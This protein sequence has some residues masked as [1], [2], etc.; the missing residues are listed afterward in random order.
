ME[1]SK[2]TLKIYGI[3]FIFLAILDVGMFALNYFLGDFKEKWNMNVVGISENTIQGVTIAFVLVIL[4][5]ALIKLFLGIRGIQQSNGTYKGK[6]H[7]T[8]A[9]I[10]I[11]M[12]IISVIASIPGFKL[13]TSV[14]INLLGNIVT[15]SILFDYIKNSKKLMNG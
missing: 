15:I 1:N 5:I 7:I 13:E 6:S 11:V 8:I 10:V 2:K 3:L 12:S 9:K 4:I 14:I